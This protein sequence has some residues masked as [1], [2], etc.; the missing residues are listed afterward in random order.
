M[1]CRE[2]QQKIKQLE[3]QLNNSE[4]LISAIDKSQAMIEFD[5]QGNILYANENFL[6]TVGYSL[7]EVIGKHH[8]IFMPAE[9]EKSAEYQKFWQNLAS[10]EFITDRFKRVN[11]QGDVVWLQASYN[12]VL[13]QSGKPIKVVKFAIDISEQVQKDFDS[14]AQVTAINKTMAVI[15]FDVQGNI[16]HANKNFLKTM[17]YELVEVKGK[18][19]K[20]FADKDY[21]QSD[22]YRVFW[23]RLESGES[24]ASNYRRIDKNGKDVWL[25]ASYNPIFDEDG[26]VVKVIKYATD[27]SLSPNALLLNK[28]VEEA[29]NVIE[30]LSDGY[31]NVK[32]ECVLDDYDGETMYEDDIAKLTKSVRNMASKLQDVI[33]VAVDAS[34]VSKESAS[35][36]T[37][38]AHAL[39]DKVQQQTKE[40]EET[41]QSVE[42]ISH[43]IKQANQHIQQANQSVNNVEQQSNR[44]M[45]VM[46]QTMQAMQSIQQSSEKIADIVTLIDSIAFQTNL[47]ALNAAVEAARAGEQGRGFAVVAG[48]VRSLAQ[49]S[50]DAAKD[51]KLLIDETVTRVD[52]GTKM[53]NDSGEVLNEINQS[54]TEVSGM[55]KHVAD[56]S[57]EQT[58]GISQ[59]NHGMQQVEKVTQESTQI[60]AD[61]LNSVE[62]LEKQ[63]EVLAADMSYFKL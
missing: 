4:G 26:K 1:F 28:V 46:Q 35:E 17:G 22:E 50:A 19:H 52:Q 57:T 25:E 62:R 10:G 54:I 58:N 20:I 27:I 3:E 6:N 48:E 29:S 8:R 53:A 39:N 30:K 36:I 42:E 23:Q 41:A 32:M 47:L 33:Q 38:G 13:D 59:V 43:A 55:I 40:L 11:K 51:I 9:E 60:V 7:P 49:K 37:I 21:A 24:F 31:L 61:T 12:P 56:S 45:E 18:H 34:R 16:L 14:N 15:E 63:S 44:G 5:L 2:Y